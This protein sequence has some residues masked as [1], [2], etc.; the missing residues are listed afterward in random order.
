MGAITD[1]REDARD[2]AFLRALPEDVRLWLSHHFRNCLA[3]I[4]AGA[5]IGRMDS[6]IEATE[7]MVADLERIGC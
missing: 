1:E 5:E 3:S 2:V 7:H 4:L 6:V